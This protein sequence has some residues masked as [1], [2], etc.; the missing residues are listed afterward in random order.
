MKKKMNWNY[1][2]IYPKNGKIVV[3]TFDNS[4]TSAVFN[5]VFEII[6]FFR[7]LL[8][9]YTVAIRIISWT[10]ILATLPCSHY[11]LGSWFIR[12]MSDIVVVLCAIWFNSYNLKNVKHPWRS[13]TYNKVAIN[14]S[15]SIHD[16]LIKLNW[17]T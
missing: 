1:N 11:L 4:N 3:W 5:I 7:N 16:N 12:N 9:F 15:F 6:I 10:E 13:V 17:L 8:F 14:K 2:P